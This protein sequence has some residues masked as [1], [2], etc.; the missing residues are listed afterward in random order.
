M[1]KHAA[2]M[3]ELK[4]LLIRHTHTEGLNPTPILN[5][6]L[7]RTSRK[8]PSY[9]QVCD[10]AIILGIQGEK[11]IHLEDRQYNYCGG[12]FM[13]LFAPIPLRCEVTQ[14]SPEKPLLA[15]IIGVEPL[16][17]A[18]MLL[19]MEVPRQAPIPSEALDASAI[20]S[21]PIGEKLLDAA[22]RLLKTL[23]S[24]TEAT[25]LSQGIVD[26]IYF[27]IIN[28]YQ[29]GALKYLL[30][31][32]GQIQ[33]ISKSIQYIRQNLSAPLTVSILADTVNMSSSGFHKRFK[34]IIHLSPIQY[35]KSLRLDRAQAMILEGKKV[36]EACYEVGYNSP[37][38]FSRE[39]KRYFGINPSET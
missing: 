36:S 28:E 37:A 18:D 13:A 38:Q 8:L 30:Q 9:R 1:N 27:R 29:D 34:E 11:F 6:S 12:N 7:I 4:E 26:E 19:K 32:H 20:F 24:P 14:A 33:Q 35:I 17:I 31:Q 5:L 22:L 3:E 10:P 23:E 15:A 25:I 2:S 21:A 16:R 39:Y